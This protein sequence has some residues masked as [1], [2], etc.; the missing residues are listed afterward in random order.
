MRLVFYTENLIRDSLVHI[1]DSNGLYECIRLEM[2]RRLSYI[3]LPEWNGSDLTMRISD[4][5][6]GTVTK[7]TERFGDVYLKKTLFQ[8]LDE[9][10]LNSLPEEE[11]K[12]KL[13]EKEQINFSDFVG[14]SD[15]LDYQQAYKTVITNITDD[16]DEMYCGFFKIF[17]VHGTVLKVVAVRKRNEQQIEPSN[18]VYSFVR[19]P[20]VED[21][22]AR[23]KKKKDIFITKTIITVLATL[24]CLG[25]TLAF[26][27]EFPY[28]KY[29][30]LGI[31]VLYFIWIGWGLSGEMEGYRVLKNNAV[32]M[33]YEAEK[34]FR[35]SFEDDEEEEDDETYGRIPW[36]Q[37]AGRY[38]ETFLTDENKKNKAP[39]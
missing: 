8:N 20:E 18:L 15:A 31:G 33:S 30:I 23:F 35:Y 5:C 32:I 2:S 1:S 16:I 24:I 12:A 29:V 13:R 36:E 26:F 11:R 21:I 3:D 6:D 10:E 34:V 17:V 28:A 39:F 38:D 9:S 14:V 27:S 19:I 22:E 25:I 37:I 7:Q 4:V